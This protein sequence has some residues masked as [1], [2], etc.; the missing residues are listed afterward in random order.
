[1]KKFNCIHYNTILWSITSEHVCHK[2]V[3]NKAIML[4]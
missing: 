2:Q 1:M 4:Q 3:S